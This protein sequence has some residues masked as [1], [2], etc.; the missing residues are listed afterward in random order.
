MAITNTYTFTGVAVVDET[1]DLLGDSMPITFKSQRYKSRQAAV[2]KDLAAQAAEFAEILEYDYNDLQNLAITVDGAVVT[3]SVEDNSYFDNYVDGTHNTTSFIT[4]ATSTTAERVSYTITPTFTAHATD[5]CGRVDCNLTFSQTINELR[6]YQFTPGGANVEILNNSSFDNTTV[7]IEL[8][9]GVLILHIYS[10]IDGQTEEFDFV[11]IPNKLEM[12]T[13]SIFN[14]SG[15][16]II[17]IKTNTF[18][19]WENSTYG[20]VKLVDPTNPEK[21]LPTSWQSSPNFNGLTPGNYNAFAKDAYGCVDSIS[22]ALDDSTST[23]G[24]TSAERKSYGLMISNKSDVRWA[25]RFNSEN[26]LSASQLALL[27]R[28]MPHPLPIKRITNIKANSQ[29]GKFQ[30][31]SNVEKHFVKIYANTSSATQDPPLATECLEIDVDFVKTSLN[32]DR[33]TALTGN[34]AYLTSQGKLAVYFTSAEYANIL[35]LWYENGVELRIDGQITA[36]IDVIVEEGVRYAVTQLTENNPQTNI[37]IRSIH[38]AKNYEVYEFDIDYSAIPYKYFFITVEG[39][40]NF[41]QASTVKPPPEDKA[42]ILWQSESMEILPDADFAAQNFHVMEFYSTKPDAEVDYS[43]K[44]LHRRNVKYQRPMRRLSQ[45]EIET[46]KLDNKITKID[47]TTNR[48]YEFRFDVMSEEDAGCLMDLL[49]ETETV[50]ID[51]VYYTTLGIAELE[52]KAPYSIVKC[53]L[54]ITELINGFNTERTSLSNPYYA[55]QT[56]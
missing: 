14:S 53:Q 24:T 3:V 20:V 1:I 11:N 26:D 22:F 41:T 27:D 51:G 38:N 56:T 18:V 55:V 12:L 32:I 54:A 39:V 19:G 36:I 47:V 44:I 34:T 42:F 7:D 43:T 17:E 35:P 16:G 48:A 31:L 6:L 46:V 52:D 13:P 8:D 21:E 23:G 10:K 33:S 28:E 25:L 40:L 37:T 30:F 29:K 5:T 15:G 4:F 9:R 45:G 50:K 49:N 2:A